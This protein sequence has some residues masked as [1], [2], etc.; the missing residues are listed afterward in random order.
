MPKAF[1]L[2]LALLM[3]ALSAVAAA[4]GV[5]GIYRTEAESLVQQWDWEDEEDPPP[6]GAWEQV[7]RYLWLAN[8]LA[9]LDAQILTDLGEHFE[10][11]ADEV[12]PAGNE[13]PADRERA[14]RLYRQAL[15]LRPAWPYNWADVASLKLSQRARRRR[16]RARPAARA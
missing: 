4:F 10:L 13:A 2:L 7:H 16:V 8:R 5:A 11:R 1:A 6:A 9:P 3:L 14:L 15:A 12:M